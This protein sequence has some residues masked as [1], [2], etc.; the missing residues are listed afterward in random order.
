MIYIADDDDGERKKS[1]STEKEIF[2]IYIVIVT[3]N[4]YHTKN[5][6]TIIIKQTF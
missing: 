5:I 6:H 3:D 2:L 4:K 1:R